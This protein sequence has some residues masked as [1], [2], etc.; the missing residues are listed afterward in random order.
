M[1]FDNRHLLPLTDV[2]GNIEDK[3]AP[4]REDPFNLF[5]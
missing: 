5:P 1:P 2:V 3:E 4:N